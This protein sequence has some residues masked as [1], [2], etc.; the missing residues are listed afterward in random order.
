[1]YIASPVIKSVKDPL[2]YWDAQ[3]KANADGGLAQFA[4]DDLSAPGKLCI[5]HIDQ[6]MLKTFTA[7]S[8]DVERAFSLGGKVITKLRNRLSEE[9]ARTSIV[10]AS[11]LEYSAFSAEKEMKQKLSE[12][13]KRRKK[14]IGKKTGAQTAEMDEDDDDMDSSL[15]DNDL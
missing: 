8:K 7:S 11:W 12:M 10:L 2:K 6:K 15:E 14:D 5:T 13:W 4:L 1:M 9:S 3:Q